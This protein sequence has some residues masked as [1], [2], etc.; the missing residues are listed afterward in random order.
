[1]IFEC[2]WHKTLEGCVLLQVGIKYEYI[3]SNFIGLLQVLSLTSAE[4]L[5]WFERA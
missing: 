1:M 2:I 3:A 4:A 5:C